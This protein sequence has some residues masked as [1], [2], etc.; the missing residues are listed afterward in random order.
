MWFSSRIRPRSLARTAR[1]GT[2]HT[3]SRHLWPSCSP[4]DHRR[5]L[6]RTS[7]VEIRV[8]SRR[9]RARPSSCRARSRQPAATTRD[10]A[11]RG[12]RRTGLPFILQLLQQLADTP[13]PQWR[14]LVKELR[15]ALGAGE[16]KRLERLANLPRAQRQPAELT[17]S[18]ECGEDEQ[19]YVTDH[20]YSSRIRS[21]YYQPRL[22]L[23]FR[24]LS[25]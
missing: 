13:Q 10:G 20:L 21:Q 23:G 7:C 11:R 5:R 18:A 3:S 9:S 6:R 12:G 16:V 4:G 15:H 17:G 14:R 8:S 2:R 22:N 25:W 1:T 19:D 24:S